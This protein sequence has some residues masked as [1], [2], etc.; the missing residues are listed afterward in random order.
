MKKK[1]MNFIV[2]LVSSIIFPSEEDLFKRLEREVKTIELDCQG[3]QYYQ[4]F[5]NHIQMV[6]P[7]SKGN[8]VIGYMA[9]KTKKNKVRS[10][11]NNVEE[12]FIQDETFDVFKG[13]RVTAEGSVSISRDL[14]VEKFDINSPPIV[15]WGCLLGL[16]DQQIGRIQI[17][18]EEDTVVTFWQQKSKRFILGCPQDKNGRPKKLK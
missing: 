6:K 14:D 2:I 13:F 11:V 12:V 1:Y 9:R 4:D 16:F 18:L 5:M 7:D 10:S 3:A 8:R 17:P 15:F